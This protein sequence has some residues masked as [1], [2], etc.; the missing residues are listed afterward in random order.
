MLVGRPEA[1]ERIAWVV[2]GARA[3]RGGALLVRGDPG[4]GK[5]SLLAAADTEGMTVLRCSGTQDEL[6]LPFAALHALVRPLRALVPGLVP[7]QREAL[8]LALGLAAG[9]QPA[10]LLVGAATLSLLD[11]A[12][13]GGP[14]LV[15]VDDFHWVDVESR[16]AIGFAARRIEDDAVGMLLAVRPGGPGLRGIDVYDLPSLDEAES[17]ALLA[18]HGVVRSVAVRLAP[19]GGGNPLALVELAALLDHEQRTGAAALPD[20]MPATSPAM[21]YARLTDSLPQSARLAAAAAASGTFSPTVLADVL[22][23]LGTGYDQLVL[24]ESTGLLRMTRAGVVWRHPLARAA[25]AAGVDSPARRRIHLCV[26]GALAAAD[27]DPATVVW[28]RVEAATGPDEA[29]AAALDEVAATAAARGAHQGAARAWETAARLGADPA[30]RLAAAAL[31]AWAADDAESASRLIEESLPSVCDPG[32]RWSLCYAAGQIAHATASP[33]QAWEWFSRGVQ[34]ARSAGDADHEIRALASSFNPALHLDN[35]ERLSMLA[36]QIRAAASPDVPGQEARASAVEGFVLLNAEITEQGRAHLEH[37]LAVIEAHDLLGTDA[38]LLPF[39]VQAAMWS[40]APTRLRGA[41]DAAIS[42]LRAAGE[43]RVRAQA[44][45]GLAWCDFSVAEWDSAAVRADDALDLARLTGRTA[46]IADALV[47]VSTLEGTRGHT[48][49]AVAHAQEARH[50][51]EGL[52]SPWRSADAWWCE[53][54]ATM[55][56]GDLDALAAPAGALGRLLLDGQVAAA[57]PEY[58]DAPLAL[59]LTGRR[60]EAQALLVVLV[61]RGGDDARPESRA[62]AVLARGAIGPD[63]ASLAREAADLAD[64]LTG[65]EYVFPR[66][67]LRLMAGAMLRRLGQR[68]E[69]RTQLRGAETDFATLGAA[70]WLLRTQDELR[71]SGATL[72]TSA[73]RDDALTAAEMRVA[74]AAAEGMSNKE[75]AAALFLSGKTVEFH[76]GRIYRKL[77]VRSR[78]ELVRLMVTTPATAGDEPPT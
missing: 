40:G 23:R 72:R 12:A 70:P 4:A 73:D 13:D 56:A 65:V 66:A 37:A 74:T 8:D 6:D 41:I 76:L 42:R 5:S 63:A 58:L 24:V 51:A 77:G 10:P 28:H 2:A 22:E 19:M 34:E 43:T 68:V 45:R 69:A 3:G 71:A 61:E 67:R 16:D 78:A 47:L 17:V 30:P 33:L 15:V 31:E 38:E 29:L 35:A 14:V 9:G 20:P 54:I 64:G 60:T 52:D 25:V 21:A 55:S 11:A 18:D 7:A 48:A 57:Q 26:A 27:G 59:A 36:R 62:G 75:I 44:V 50:I 53:L 32:L 46:D 1:F 39:A 49:D